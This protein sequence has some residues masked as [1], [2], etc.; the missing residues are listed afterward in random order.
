MSELNKQ[1]VRLFVDAVLNQG[2]LE[3]IDELVAADYVGHIP[4]AQRE[5][6]GRD[7]L[8]QLVIDHR[9]THPDLYIKIEN[10]IAEDD[11]VVMRWRSTAGTPATPAT[12]DGPPGCWGISVIRLLAGRQVDTYTAV[13]PSATNLVA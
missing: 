3:L 8:R 6:R 11:L 12:I 7:Q 13:A 4:C 2:R 5:V 10:E 1:K 9:R